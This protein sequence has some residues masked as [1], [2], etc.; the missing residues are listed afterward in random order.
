MYVIHR[1]HG[2]YIC[3]QGY[4]YKLKGE[5]KWK[6]EGNKR[7]QWWGKRQNDNAL[8]GKLNKKG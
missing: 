7:Y 8:Y 6:Y 3:L 4:G 5:G 1:T 2:R